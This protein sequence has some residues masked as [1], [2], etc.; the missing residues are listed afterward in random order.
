MSQ[1][2]ERMRPG[3]RREPAVITGHRSAIDMGPRMGVE[4]DAPVPDDPAERDLPENPI[5]V[6]TID[7]RHLTPPNPE[8]K[9]RRFRS[10]YWSHRVLV[11]AEPDVVLAGGRVKQGKTKYAQFNQ[12]YL[13]TED[14]ETIKALTEGRNFGSDYWDADEMDHQAALQSQ[15]AYEDSVR[16]NPDMLRGLLEKVKA[17]DFDDVLG[18]KPEAPAE[19]AQ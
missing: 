9:K 5:A 10:K 18:V 12:G 14:Q 11:S 16:R 13:E 8:R 2:T 19:A 17:G 3:R 15:A 4:K 1:T 7:P 6:P